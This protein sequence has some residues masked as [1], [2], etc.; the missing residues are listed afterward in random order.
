MP[1]FSATYKQAPVRA[2]VE[3]IYYD[4]NNIKTSFKTVHD[5]HEFNP[6]ISPF[7]QSGFDV[8]LFLF[9]KKISNHS[10]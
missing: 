9:I 6:S 7:A 2:E 1:Y 8:N 4:N 3:G 5:Y 10:I